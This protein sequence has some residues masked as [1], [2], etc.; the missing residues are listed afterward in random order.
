MVKDGTEWSRPDTTIVRTGNV[1]PVADAGPDQTLGGSPVT[2][3]L[4]G[5]GSF[6]DDL[7]TLA[8]DWAL[9]D[10]PANSNAVI[11]DAA[12]TQTVMAYADANCPG[13][14]PSVTRALGLAEETT[15]TLAYDP[16]TCN[17]TSMIDPL[18]NPSSLAYDSAGNV[19][20]A[21][22]AL[23]RESR[24]VYDGLNR[25]T[26]SIDATNSDPAPACGVAGVTCFACDAGA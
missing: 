13:S 5:S 10:Q 19:I 2:A 12:L 8:Y 4:D 9:T 17:L 26:K 6:D 1:A 7:D 21:T 18:G 15:T 22:D 3:F 14:V 11:T 24:F 20:S 23:L 16:A 25:M